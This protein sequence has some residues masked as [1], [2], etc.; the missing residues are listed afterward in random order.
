MFDLQERGYGVDKG[1][2]TFVV[3]AASFDDV[4]AISGFSMFIGL[5]TGGSSDLA[6][7]ILGGPLNI[8]VG[9]ACG[10]AAGV[11]LSWTRIWN[12]DWKRSIVLILLAVI[13]KFGFKN[14]KGIGI[15]F[16]GAGALGALI[17]ACVAAQMWQRGWG[18]PLATGT[19]DHHASHSAETYLCFL[20]KVVSEPLL[21]A[22]IGSALDFSTLKG[23][24]IPL[25]CLLLVG[26][27]A[28]RTIMALVATHSAGLNMKER[29]FVALAWLPKASVQAALGA[30]PLAKILEE[31]ADEPD[32][33]DWKAWGSDILTTA[34]LSI[35]LT[36]P[37]GLLAIQHLGP[38]WLEKSA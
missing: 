29:L 36:A 18:G 27:V 19:P 21:F 8:I 26:C 7:L 25:A 31:K 4:V 17:M 33:E 22:V 32:F 16:D 28:V 38:K 12:T 30:I 9:F 23:S 2:P 35:I 37:L 5:A 13:M 34:V 15:E 10:A 20:W 11:I 14:I 1:I 3:A 6:L 24:T